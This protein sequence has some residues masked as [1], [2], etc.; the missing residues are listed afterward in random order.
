MEVLS[1]NT[2]SQSCG[3]CKTSFPGDAY[4]I[5]MLGNTTLGHGSTY[6][7]PGAKTVLAP[8]FVNKRLLGHITSTNFCI[9]YTCFH[10]ITIQLS[11]CICLRNPHSLLYRNVCWYLLS[12]RDKAG[13][14][15]NGE[16]WLLS[17]KTAKSTCSE[18]VIYLIS[19]GVKQVEGAHL[20][21]QFIKTSSESR[22]AF[23]N[24]LKQ[25]DL[26]L[27]GNCPNITDL[28]QNYV[29]NYMLLTRN[30]CKEDMMR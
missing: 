27:W 13:S 25:E 12:T 8:M 7:S 23:R 11:S 9:V 6:Y 2:F 29:L 20:L 30:S 15:R 1:Q 10:I 18:R 21:L 24:I 19:L 14:D 26:C 5:P 22:N 16:N 3:Y 4:D 28:K 17:P